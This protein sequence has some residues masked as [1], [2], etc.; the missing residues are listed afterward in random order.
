M[1]KHYFLLAVWILLAF[2]C[3]AQNIAINA[4]G[5]LPNTNAILDIKSGNKG[6]LIP[7]LDSTARKAIPATKGLLVYDTT[8]NSF[9]YN[10][11]A[12]WQN[13][14][15]GTALSLSVADSAWLLTGNGNARDTVN[16]LGTTNNV[17]LNI[18]V[19]NQPSGRIDGTK[20]NTFWGY[21]AG[22]V[23]TGSYNT[24]IGAYSLQRN[25]GGDR[26]TANG[27]WAMFYNTSGYN[28]TAM[29]VYSMYYNTSG[30]YNAALGLGSLNYNTS[31]YENT[32]SGTDALRSNTTGIDNTANGY[33]SLF[34]N[35][36]NAET[37]TGY[38]SMYSNTLG[39]DNTADGYQSLY[40]NITG[41]GNTAMGVTSM[42][43][44]T[45]GFFNAAIGIGSLNNNTTGSDN[46]ASG[47]SSLSWN[48][49]G[50][51]NT[52]D[53]YQSLYS[54]NADGETATGYQSM[55]FNM[56]GADNTAD[57]YQT[58]YYN[59]TGVSNTANGYLAMY[60]NRIGSLNTATG[61]QS[62]YSTIAGYSDVADGFQA[63]F[64]NSTGTGNTAVGAEAMPSNTSGSYNT[65]IGYQ[66]NVS[67]PSLFNATAIG[68]NTIVD[69][70]NKVRIGNSAV[71]VIEGQVPFTTPS[72]GRYKFNVQEDVK[73][74]DFILHL[75]P[76]TY[77]FDV[78]RF[79]AQLN[80]QAAQEGQPAQPAQSTQ[81]SK[82]QPVNYA[83][84]TAYDEATRIRRSGFIAQ[85]VEKAANATGYDFS[86]IIKPKTDEDHYS[87][88]YDAFVVPLVKAVQEQQQ[89]ID[90]QNKKIADLQQQI[91]EIKKLLQPAPSRN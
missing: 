8:T 89:I 77:Q 44:N 74:L 38:Q 43:Y 61:V 66:S 46:M 12:Q 15:A 56:T 31:G 27:T 58:L 64:F 75:R 83:M 51:N 16:F 10:T 79:D 48:T 88:S 63:L 9:W 73:G 72:D 5:S 91:N 52:A 81:P 34:Y 84:Q 21:L 7:R 68:S 86:G 29:G 17:P 59:S 71:T 18:R 4:D 14:A 60:S 37:A 23:D 1:T 62:L 80:H 82:G 90:T 28:N 87:L 69:A 85:E 11:G 76:V 30:Y 24:A 70:S 39:T 42:Y 22:S 6:I 2:P 25:I 49:T 50:S 65:A 13:I 57:G 45:T 41:G 19:N 47:T 35:N 26:N 36:A 78:Q 3:L 33:Q 20:E 55:Y 40:S 54:N 67:A 53:G 32:A